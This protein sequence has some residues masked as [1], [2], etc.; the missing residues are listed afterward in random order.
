MNAPNQKPPIIGIIN[1]E[2][3]AFLQPL[4]GLKKLS[5]RDGQVLIVD[6]GGKI[7]LCACSPKSSSSTSFWPIIHAT[8]GRRMSFSLPIHDL[9]YT[10]S[11]MPHDTIM[12]IE[13]HCHH[14]AIRNPT[15]FGKGHEVILDKG[16][17]SAKLQ[18]RT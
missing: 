10:C 14:V 16:K 6:D 7:T 5:R 4:S 15:A 3:S 8:S 18:Q 11:M 13:I 2:V 9:H 17:S 1:V 12:T